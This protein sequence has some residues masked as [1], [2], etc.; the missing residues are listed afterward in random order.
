SANDH[1]SRQPHDLG[2]RA[3]TATQN[4][5]TGTTPSSGHHATMPEPWGKPA[6]PN[7]GSADP[8]AIPDDHEHR[9]SNIPGFRE[10]WPR[11]A[12]T[13]IGG[14]WGRLV[15]PV[16]KPRSTI[17]TWRDRDV[18]EFAVSRTERTALCAPPPPSPRSRSATCWLSLVRLRWA[19]LRGSREVIA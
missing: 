6:S 11:I 10:Q 15:R 17:V 7:V 19:G 12:V 16:I 9:M 1:G 2:S 5:G 18:I 13:H 3:C 8:R 4:A 14:K